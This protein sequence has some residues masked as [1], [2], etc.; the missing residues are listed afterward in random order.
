MDIKP[1]KPLTIF[2]K[3]ALIWGETDPISAPLSNSTEI[4]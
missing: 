3:I 4:R 2:M 1:T